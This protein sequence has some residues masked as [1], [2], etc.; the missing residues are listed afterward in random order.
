MRRR[1]SEPL[2]LLVNSYNPPPSYSSNAGNNQASG[3]RLINTVGNTGTNQPRVFRCYNCNG[4]GHM[5]KQCTARKRVKDFEWF[6]EKM[7][8]AQAQ[9][10]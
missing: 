6:K 5:A 4:E 9:E 8:L 7:L 10:A 3:A 2:A 1:F